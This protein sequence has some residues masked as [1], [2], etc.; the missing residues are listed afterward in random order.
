[1]INSIID[2]ISITLNAEF[3]DDYKIYTED[4]EQ[5]LKEPCFFVQCINPTNDRFLGNKYKRTHQFCIQYFPSSEDKYSECMS[6]TDRLFVALDIV[7]DEWMGTKMNGEVVDG[8]LHFFVN[9]DTFAYRTKE[10]TPMETIEHQ[11]NVKGDE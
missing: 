6:V 2:A 11:S 7:G 1:M 10:E 9:Y 3:G 4:I 5:G 8:V